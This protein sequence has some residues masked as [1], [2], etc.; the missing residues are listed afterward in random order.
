M[1]NSFCRSCHWDEI[2][3]GQWVGG[4]G[5]G[6]GERG[7]KERHVSSSKPPPAVRLVRVMVQRGAVSSASVEDWR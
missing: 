1:E 5:V 3:R 2:E 7:Q 4:G 6:V